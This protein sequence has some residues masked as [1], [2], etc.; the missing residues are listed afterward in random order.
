MLVI[1]WPFQRQMQASKQMASLNTVVLCIYDN[2]FASNVWIHILYRV[3]ML[4]LQIHD[5]YDWIF[6]IV[7]SFIN[8]NAHNK[9]EI[10]KGLKYQERERP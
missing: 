2:V 10:C 4:T 8:I 7:A 5:H 6:T 1:V 9:L 3:Y